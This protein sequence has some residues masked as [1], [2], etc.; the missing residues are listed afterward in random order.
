MKERERIRREEMEKR[1]KAELIILENKKKEEKRRREQEERSKFDAKLVKTK[2]DEVI[3]ISLQKGE[4][5]TLYLDL[6]SFVNIKIAFLLTDVEDKVYYL[7]SGPDSRGRTSILYKAYDKNYL[8]HEY[9]TLRKGEYI[10]EITNRGKKECE[11]ML[12]VKDHNEMKK[13]TIDTQK[14]D[15]ISMLLTEIDNNVNNLRNKKKM[16]VR[17][18]NSH[19]DKV[20]ANNRSIVI[21]SII[22]IFTMI[23]V[24]FIQSYYI[25]SIVAKV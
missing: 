10:I 18:V 9:E 24:F 4:S 1:A 6:N 15:R 23:I 25:S 16:E 8:F 3:Q 13:D 11:L 17:Q 20:D 21:Y 2:F 14:I 7:F 22:E 19:N 12:F 5:E